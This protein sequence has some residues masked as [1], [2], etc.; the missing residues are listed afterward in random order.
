VASLKCLGRRWQTKTNLRRNKLQNKYGECLLPCRSESF[1]LPSVTQERK[2]VLK[3]NSNFTCWFVWA[4]RSVCRSVRLREEHWLHLRTVCWGEYLDLRGNTW[5][6][7][8]NEELD[9]L[10]SSSN[11]IGRIKWR[12]MRLGY[13]G[14]DTEC[15]QSFGGKAGK[16][17][18][19]RKIDA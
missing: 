15:R 11:I 5:I 8:H 19:T 12:L 16:K 18:S 1:L 17:E 3:R 10:F 2:T 9:N 4:C 6:N 7:M 13:S 14:E